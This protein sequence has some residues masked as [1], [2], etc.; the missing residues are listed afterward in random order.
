[1]ESVEPADYVSYI[2][3]LV[4]RMLRY[5]GHFRDFASGATKGLD[6]TKFCWRASPPTPLELLHPTPSALPSSVAHAQLYSAR[7]PRSLLP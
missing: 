2:E 6:L 5:D 3:Q 4:R 1:M 7:R